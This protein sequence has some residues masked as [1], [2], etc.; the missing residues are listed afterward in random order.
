[1]PFSIIAAV[2]QSGGIG[3]G[4]KLPWN[5]KG[6]LKHFKEVTQGQGGP[7]KLNAVI[8]GRTTWDSI[9]AR[10][11]PLAG[12]INLVL[13]RTSLELPPGVLGATSLDQA[14]ELA[15]GQGA[16]E[17]FVIGGASVYAQAIAHPACQTI[18]LTEIESAFE[19]DTF[20]PAVP[21]EFFEQTVV[22][23]PVTEGGVTYR[24]V[25]YSRKK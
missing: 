4:G 12:R 5:L 13:S 25:T 6:D 10:F 16:G 23:D 14:L 8:M 1:M 19:C 21:P 22:S 7:A 3:Q 18:C 2:D 24:F 11:R 15:E 9:P 20:F 17:V